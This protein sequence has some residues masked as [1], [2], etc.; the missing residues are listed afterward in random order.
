MR[1]PF[2][3]RKTPAETPAD[4]SRT[5]ASVEEGA[6]A[7]E[8]PDEADDSFA[9]ALALENPEPAPARVRRPRKKRIIL[10]A[11]IVVAAVGAAAVWRLRGA[12]TP[13]SAEYQYIRTVTLSLGSLDDSVTATGTVAAGQEADVT[14]AENART[15][16]IATIEVAVGDEVEQGDVIA[17]LDTTDLLQQI[18]QAEQT[19]ADDLASAQTTYDRA[20][21]SYEVAVVQHENNLID[22]QEAIDTAEETYA[23][24]EEA[25]STAQDSYNAA[26]SEYN[27]LNTA[28]NEVSSQISSFTEAYQAAADALNTAV[29]DLNN[30]NIS[31]DTAA[32]E[33]ATAAVAQAQT[34]ADEAYQALTDAQNNCAV[35]ERGLYG[36]TAIEQA[37]STAQQSLSTA[38]QALTQAETALE[39]AETQRQTA[40][41]NYDNE[42]NSTTL[43]TQ[44]Q[45]VE[46]ALTRLE[47]AQRTSSEL[48]TLQETL[49][50]C[51]LTATM[52]GTVTAL[53]ATVGATAS[54]TVATIQ[55][56]DALVVEVTV[57]A[58]D[59]ADLTTGM[60]CRITSDATG[61]TEIAGTLTQIDPVANEQGTF[62]AEV[63][64]TGD[65]SGL[66]VGIQAEVE[67]IKSEVGDVFTVPIDAVGTSEDGSSYVLRRTGGEGT[68]MTFEEVTVTT[69]EQND[70]YV[71]ISSDSLSEGDEIRASADLTQGIVTSSEEE[72]AMADMTMPGMGGDM[73]GMPAG[74]GDMPSGGPSG[75]MPGGM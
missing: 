50:D 28:Y 59:V 41:D 64:V 34:A 20:V 74:G 52:S 9:Q 24:A 75:G 53:N 65:A 73:G 11:V 71:V 1:L 49:A 38:D 56:T 16:P 36:F 63:Q 37:L 14:V 39:T 31:G 48:T 25:L 35:A 66:L 45:N 8:N 21:S 7:P 6:D 69:G 15:Y 12:A 72:E 10:A 46:D 32:I 70:Y 42:K 27:A 33:T 13:A 22:L 54:D 60:T 68:E 3:D 23:D 18:E 57:S 58:D 4:A 55:D 67:I 17:T 40:Y 61:D 5:A 2:K 19:Y 47:Q 44:A 51:T 26:E 43:T 30:A 62:G 29:S